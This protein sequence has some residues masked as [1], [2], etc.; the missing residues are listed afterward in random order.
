MT[1]KELYQTIPHNEATDIVKKNFFNVAASNT[2]NL[3]SA[4]IEFL[5]DWQLKPLG[6]KKGIPWLFN[7]ST[8]SD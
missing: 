4:E 1:W 5:R 2:R 6:L 8:K 7:S 3:T